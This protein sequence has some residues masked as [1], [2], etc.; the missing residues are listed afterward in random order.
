MP[1]SIRE[2]IVKNV[3]ATLEGVTGINSVQRL[4]QSGMTT[5]TVPCVWIEEGQETT[6][7][8][9][10]FTDRELNLAIALVERH[11]ETANNL[12]SAEHLAPLRDN[13]DRGL[14]ADVTRG[15]NADNTTSI[16]WNA[17]E[18]FEGQSELIQVGVFSVAYST[19]PK[20]P[21]VKV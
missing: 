20:D 16:S 9:Q 8:R 18:A 14:S 4:R 15:G 1:D 10:G 17:V 6:Q 3:Q 2:L 5:A 19:N 21:A 12:S 11:D 13:I 7:D